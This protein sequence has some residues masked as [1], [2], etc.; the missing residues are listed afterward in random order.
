MSSSE[1]LTDFGLAKVVHK[2]L[3]RGEQ[4][5]LGIAKQVLV[6]FELVELVGERLNLL[7]LVVDHFDVFCDFLR[8]VLDRLNVHGGVE[9]DPLRACR[10]RDAERHERE[11]DEFF[12]GVPFVMLSLSAATRRQSRER[13][14]HQAKK[15]RCITRTT[16]SEVREKEGKENAISV[17]WP[18]CVPSESQ[19]R[20]L[21]RSSRSHCR[22]FY[23]SA[24]SAGLHEWSPPFCQ[25][26]ARSRG[27]ASV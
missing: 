20:W 6:M 13:I 19:R 5:R 1:G 18:D 14:Y 27:A 2:R 16:F 7:H 10:H 15:M 8:C 11:G 3:N 26:T 4:D 23:I 21:P 9:Y 24:V 22:S 25:C 12:H 17:R